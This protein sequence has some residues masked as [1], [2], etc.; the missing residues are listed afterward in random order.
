[1]EAIDAS[2]GWVT[3]IMSEVS[4][5]DGVGSVED[6]GEGGGEFIAPLSRGLWW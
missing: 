2:V 4:G 1:M 6:G 5:S 3:V